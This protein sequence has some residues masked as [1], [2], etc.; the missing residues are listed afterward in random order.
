MIIDQLL[1]SIA[2]DVREAGMFS[3]Q[4]DTTQ[5]ISVQD[6]C[7]VVVRY[8]NSKG[9]QEKLLSL[10]TVQKSTGK[11]FADMLTNISSENDLDIKKC[12]GNL[13]NLHSRQQLYL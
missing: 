6:Q 4:L 13:Q 5:D 1:K 7:S 9:I 11:S 3:T 10:V 12:I 8:V 2:N